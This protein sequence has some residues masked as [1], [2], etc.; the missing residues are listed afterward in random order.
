MKSATWVQIPDN[1]NDFGKG[2]DPPI[3]PLALSR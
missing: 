2:I 1:A 3:L